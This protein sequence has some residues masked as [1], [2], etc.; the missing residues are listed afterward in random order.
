M[1]QDFQLEWFG[2]N[3][4]R[5]F[6]AL[7]PGVEAIPWG[8]LDRSK[9]PPLLAERCRAYWTRTAFG[10]YRAAALF[11][12]LVQT[13]LFAGVP[14]DFVG[15]VSNFVTD[16]ISHVELASR[17]AMELG[18]GTPYRADFSSLRQPPTPGLTPLQR[19]NDEVL[20]LC[21]IETF[22]TPMLASSLA[23]CNHP[24]ISS[25][26]KQVLRDEAPHGRFG[27]DY[28]RWAEA[29]MDDEERERLARLAVTL[30]TELVT[31]QRRFTS[32]AVDGVTTE[33][34]LVEHINELGWLEAQ[35]YVRR[36]RDVIVEKVVAPLIEHGLPIDERSLPTELAPALDRLR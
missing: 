16:E 2:G 12:Q 14:V 36:A 8:T 21:C 23:V 15:V 1:A 18:G 35:D 3:V 34:F 6:H 17:V 25:V 20:R 5:R 7:R 24:L 28:L 19:S 33:G 10:E 22:N 26:L 11:S 9:Y 30:V 27:F 31:S 13:M 4:E 29:E 32:T